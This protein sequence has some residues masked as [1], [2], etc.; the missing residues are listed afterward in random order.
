MYIDL[1]IG[2]PSVWGHK[3]LIPGLVLQV[4]L[5]R[6]PHNL[7]LGDGS[8]YQTKVTRLPARRLY[9]N[10]GIILCPVST[11]L[12]TCPE[13]SG[14][15]VRYNQVQLANSR[16]TVIHIYSQDQINGGGNSPV[17]THLWGRVKD[18]FNPGNPNR[19]RQPS[20]VQ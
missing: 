9:S 14:G 4:R 19:S 15:P 17:H 8:G 1:E 2:P 5:V 18:E 16:S 3:Y 10:S 20:R 12:H 7:Y 6:L 11:S 13:V